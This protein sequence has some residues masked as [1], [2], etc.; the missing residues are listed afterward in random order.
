MR[1][2]SHVPCALPQVVPLAR[3]G[4]LQ[5][6]L[7]A[8]AMLWIALAVAPKYR[9]DW[10]LEN[11]LVFAFVGL[12]VATYRR[13]AFSNFSYA[14]IALFLALHAVGAHST[15][16]ETPVGFVLQRWLALPRNP[17]D[18]VV[19]FAYGLL[20]G[21]PLRELA[22]RTLRADRLWAFLLAL[23]G[24]LALSGGYEILESWVARI[25]SPE[26]GAAYL[27]TQG[28]E[29]DAQKDMSLALC[30]ALVGLSA[31][32][33]YRCWAGREAWRLLAPR[34][35]SPGGGRSA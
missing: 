10:L 33:L 23:S 15:Y 24:T 3:N 4:R 5:A 27:G 16:S 19:H 22:L 20:L 32:E 30:G 14:L 21:Y 35:I 34:G 25:V 13:F 18:R 12:L 6:I 9:L 26:L 17:Y 28:D 2:R 29:W 31:A 1:G 11:L 7:A 8:T